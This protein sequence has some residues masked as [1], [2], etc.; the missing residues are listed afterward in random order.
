MLEHTIYL[1]RSN[2]S[3]V[4]LSKVVCFRQFTCFKG[5]IIISI[6]QSAKVGSYIL[7]I[8]LMFY[9]SLNIRSV[10]AS[11]RNICLKIWQY[12]Y[13]HENVSCTYHCFLTL[14]NI[15]CKQHKHIVSKS[16]CC[17]MMNVKKSAPF[18][19]K[20]NIKL[21]FWLHFI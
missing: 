7:I 14:N 15:L 1:R 20:K 13:N 18:Q 21:T 16:S 3:I 2:F 4:A 17:Q 8:I 9:I 6:D 5:V 11:I 12:R 19:K 10:Q